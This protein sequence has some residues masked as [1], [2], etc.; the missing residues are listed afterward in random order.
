MKALVYTGPKQVEVK[1][2]K[3]PE[4]KEGMIRLEVQYCGVCGS[5]IGIYMGTHPRAKAPLILGHEFLGIAAEDGKKKET[6]SYLIHCFPVEHV[7]PVEP[8]ISM[9]V[10]RWDFWESIWMVACVRRYMWMK[11]YCS[12]FQMKYPMRWQR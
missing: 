3:V 12:G 9:Y 11:M 1:E 8:E 2:M 6:G 5:D 4:K 7:L 10:T